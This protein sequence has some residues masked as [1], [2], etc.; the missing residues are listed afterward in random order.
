MS[1][2]SRMWAMYVALHGGDH[3][4]TMQHMRRDGIRAKWPDDE[5]LNR[6]RRGCQVSDQ[7]RFNEK[8]WEFISKCYAD[9]GV[10]TIVLGLRNAI[11][12]PSHPELAIK[13]AWSP[14][15]LREELERLRGM[16]FEVVPKLNFSTTHDAWLKEYHLMVSTPEYYKVCADVI[17]DVCE[18][19]GSPRLFHIGFDEEQ[20]RNHHCEPIAIARQGEL[21]WHDLQFFIDEV[22]RHGARTWMW[23]DHIAKESEH[24]KAYERLPKSV[25]LSPWYYQEVYD[26]DKTWQVKA[27]HELNARGFEMIP[28]G[29]NHYFTEDSMELLVSY[30]E[31]HFD[32]SL[33][34]GYLCA[35]W[36]G[37]EPYFRNRNLKA[38]ESVK[39]ARMLAKS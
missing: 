30:C 15:K 16:G 28:C 39:R 27:M 37:I 8:E 1:E 4:C 9:A 22:S 12:Y 36:V 25:V 34:P 19:F 5:F 3:R 23:V 2:R 29:S 24:T 26:K 35:P 32:R 33:I 21:W 14:A 7:M 18:M 38:A 6:I 10:N 31:E 20:I 13:G 17:R 11:V